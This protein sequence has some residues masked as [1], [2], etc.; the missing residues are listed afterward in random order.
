MSVKLDNRFFNGIRLVCASLIFF[1]SL[2]TIF[3]CSS[4]SMLWNLKATESGAY[5]FS[6]ALLI[7][8]LPG[9][10]FKP[11]SLITRL[12]AL[13]AAIL[14]LSPAWQ[15]KAFMKEKGSFSWKMWM[16]GESFSCSM[17]DL[18]CTADDGSELNSIICIPDQPINRSP[19]VLVL[20]GGG[21]TTGSAIHGL[22][23]AKS[24]ASKGY[25]SISV[26]YRLAPQTTFPGQINDIDKVWKAFK[27][28]YFSTSVDTSAMFLIGESAGASIVL[29][30]AQFK[31][32]PALKGLINLYGITDF[33][34]AGESSKEN[35]SELSAMVNAYRGENTAVSISPSNPELIASIPVLTIHGA[36]DVAVSNIQAVKFHEFRLENNFPSTLYILPWSSHLFNH[37]SSG[38]SGQVSKELIINFIH[39]N[40]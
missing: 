25:Y 16:A 38:P 37:P 11:V 4:I 3:S 12:L 36:R 27:N 14:L 17:Q 10:S 31:E 20:H 6:I 5:I 19:C 15:A 35:V 22:E 34:F 2:L 29:N 26:D 24:L 21:F 32:N 18:I 8:I 1:Y 33:T 13:F 23:L 28:S 9:Y 30:Y 7:V 40:H 39:S